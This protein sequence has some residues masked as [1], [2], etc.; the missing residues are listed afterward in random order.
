MS[1]QLK[2]WDDQA[3]VW[4]D[5]AEF[6]IYGLVMRGTIDLAPRRGVVVKHEKTAGG[7]CAQRP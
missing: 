1:C 7:R 4:L 5:S 6:G 3:S 2:S